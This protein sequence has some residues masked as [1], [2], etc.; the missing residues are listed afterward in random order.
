MYECNCGASAPFSA[1]DRFCSLIFSLLSDENYVL[2]LS[3]CQ[4]AD[5]YLFI[6]VLKMKV[7][8]C[9]ALLV[10]VVVCF[11][12]LLCLWFY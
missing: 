9:R 6:T 3:Y 1:Y 11:I 12:L 10:H 5:Y 7:G 8:I 2:I 4:L